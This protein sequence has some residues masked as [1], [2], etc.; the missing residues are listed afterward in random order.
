MLKALQALSIAGEGLR[1]NFDCDG[2]IKSNIP[3]AINL[4]HPAGTNGRK[5]LIRSKLSTRGEHFECAQ[6]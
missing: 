5:N 3:G 2:A 1:Q 4:A 6:L